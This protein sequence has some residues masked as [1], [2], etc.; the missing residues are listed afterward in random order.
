MDSIFQNLAGNSSM[1]AAISNTL[2]HSIWQGIV[3]AG[4]LWTALKIIPTKKA[5]VRHNLSILSLVLLIVTIGITFSLENQNTTI[6][7]SY[8]TANNN[9]LVLEDT[10]NLASIEGQMEILQQ[11]IGAHNVEIVSIWV[12]GVFLFSFRLIGGLLYLNQ[13]K[14]AAFT[15]QNTKRLNDTIESIKNRLKIRKVVQV[16]ESTQIEVPMVMGYLKPIILMPA[17]LISGFKME[18]IEAV[19]LHEMAHIKRNDYLVNIF[20]YVAESVLFFNPGVWILSKAINEEREHCCDDMAVN[21]FEN[22]MAYIKA[23]TNVQSFAMNKTVALA[24]AEKKQH[25]IHRIKRIMK[26]TTNNNKSKALPLVM[27]TAVLVSLVWYKNSNA[28]I[29]KETAEAPATIEMVAAEP[30]DENSDYIRADTLLPEIPE[31]P[32]LPPIPDFDQVHEMEEISEATIERME[33]IERVQ[34]IEEI[35]AMGA[36]SEMGNLESNNF[37]IFVDSIPEEE[38]KRMVVAQEKLMRQMLEV[39][40]QNVMLLQEQ[41]RVL[42]NSELDPEEIIQL[43]K[44]KLQELHELSKER[45]QMSLEENRVLQERVSQE[46]KKEMREHELYLKELDIKLQAFEKKMKVEEKKFQEQINAQLVKDGYIKKGEKVNNIQFTEDQ[47]TVNNIKIK[48]KDFKKY[49]KLMDAFEK[50][51][52]HIEE[53]SDF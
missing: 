45:A 33:D 27:I 41:L 43:N 37:R 10:Y 51:I 14:R 46:M 6:L 31:N 17:G 44:E 12:V 47:I 34:L 21:Y 2:L 40:E 8:H 1:F 18:E 22:K 38:Y 15:S 23:L 4:I 35:K 42:E 11:A 26:T 5:N 50:S 7:A 25:L 30:L 36:L 24:L 20:Q 52:E 49:K 39:Q 3:F 48:D 28:E 13:L 9:V 53:L 19:L 29:F 32:P 16:L